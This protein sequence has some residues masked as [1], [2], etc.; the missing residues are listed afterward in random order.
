MSIESEENLK[1]IKRIGRI[2]GLVLK[3]MKEYEHTVVVT[4]RRPIVVTR[5][6]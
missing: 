6:L 2:V 3:E 4:R 1:G 5:V